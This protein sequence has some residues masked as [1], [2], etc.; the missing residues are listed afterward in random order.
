MSVGG[1]AEPITRGDRLIRDPIY[2]YIR[3][4]VRLIPFLDHPA[5]Q[6]LRRVHQTSL[7][8]MVYPASTHSRF[9]HSLG[10][11]HLARRAW[12]AAWSNAS[13]AT[14][15]AFLDAMRADRFDLPAA[16][17]RDYV[18]DA[19]ACVGL[20]HDLGHPPMS[21]VLEDD[22]HARLRDWVIDNE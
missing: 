19:I 4:S 22:F 6:R 1:L 11:M 15:Q 20:L 13:S 16:E 14:Q 2:G 18:G 9:E 12:L 17:A 7:T 3:V 10:T 5:V 8:Q 21:H